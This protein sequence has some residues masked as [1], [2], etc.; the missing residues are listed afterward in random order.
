[1]HRDSPREAAAENTFPSLQFR[2][3]TSHRY[4]IARRHHVLLLYSCFSLVH[5]ILLFAS[6]IFAQCSYVVRPSFR[7]WQRSWPQP[8][9]SFWLN[10][11]VWFRAEDL[12]A[13]SRPY[14]GSLHTQTVTRPSHPPHPS[15]PPPAP[16]HPPT[17]SPAHPPSHL[18]A[19]HPPMH[20]PMHPSI[21]RQGIC[22][23]FICVI[24]C[25]PE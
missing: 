10:G 25:C 24:L 1:M 14:A 3:P 16:S 5:Y 4:H 22:A 17:H 12:G 19:S 11:H 13:C 8:P 9:G 6:H 7:R 15:Q 2:N 21:H 23:L 18:L 20:P